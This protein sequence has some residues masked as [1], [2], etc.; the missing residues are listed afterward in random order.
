MPNLVPCINCEKEISSRASRCPICGTT[1]SQ[2][3]K[4]GVCGQRLREKLA[5]HLS[6]KH[7]H[8]ECLAPIAKKF[9][10]PKSALYCAD[11]RALMD[12]LPVGTLGWLNYTIDPCHK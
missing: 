3:A 4:C 5:F 10:S 12:W 1:E 8:Q 7:F 9:F 2:N 6:D 11:C